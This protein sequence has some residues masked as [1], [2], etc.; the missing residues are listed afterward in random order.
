MLSILS[1]TRVRVHFALTWSETPI[2]VRARSASVALG[3]GF[4]FSILDSLDGDM[5]ALRATAS[6][7]LPD[8]TRSA[9]SAA[10][11]CALFTPRTWPTI[12]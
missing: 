6:A 11:S 12:R 2:A 3:A 5:R 1:L 7:S 9:R 8:A 4:T 10:P